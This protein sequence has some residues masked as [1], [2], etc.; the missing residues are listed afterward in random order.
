MPTQRGRW[1]RGGRL[2]IPRG[3]CVHDVQKRERCRLGTPR[4]AGRALGLVGGDWSWVPRRLLGVFVSPSNSCSLALT[5]CQAQ[6]LGTQM[7]SVVTELEVGL[8]GP[9]EWN[10]RESAL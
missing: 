9:R 8:K 3:A 2:L 10:F 7:S 4:G 1:G 5:E 6:M